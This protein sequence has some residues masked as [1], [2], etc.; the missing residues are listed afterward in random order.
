MKRNSQSSIDNRQST[1]GFTLVELLV[2]IAII[3]LLAGIL[4]PT[5]RS[6]LLSAA[7]AKT[8]TRI[9]ELSDG[10]QAYK[11]D[12]NSY[13]YYPGQ[14]DWPA[15]ISATNGSL[16]LANALFTDSSGTFP[17]SNYAGCK[18]KDSLSDNSISDRFSKGPMAIMYY[19]AAIGGSG[20]AQYSEGHNSTHTTGVTWETPSGIT[21]DFSHYVQDRRFS[22]DSSTTP[23]H[24]GMFLLIA[25]GKDRT[26]GTSDDITNWK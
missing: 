17:T 4:I 3:A 2:V 24:P 26:Y 19:P 7:V 12:N 1:I 13:P 22:G 20:L 23:Q 5:I 6:S 10:T 21:D 25:A 9:R 18:T 16:L 11:D 8:R 15:S 14:I